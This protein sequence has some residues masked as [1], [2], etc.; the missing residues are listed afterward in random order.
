MSHVKTYLYKGDT[1]RNKK[2][3]AIIRGD[4]Q[5]WILQIVKYHNSEAEVKETAF[6]VH[7]ECQRPYIENMPFLK[8][9][10]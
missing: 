2:K 9:F 1:I 6:W 4:V 8:L 5:G 10:C 3:R 7:Y